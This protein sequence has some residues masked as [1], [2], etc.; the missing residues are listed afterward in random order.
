MKKANPLCIYSVVDNLKPVKGRG[1]SLYSFVKTNGVVFHQ[2]V[3]DEPDARRDAC[4]F[5]VGYLNASKDELYS[6]TEGQ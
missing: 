5:A 3:I 1:A 6:R 4:A 2:E